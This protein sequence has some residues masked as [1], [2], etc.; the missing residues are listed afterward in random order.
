MTRC[1]NKTVLLPPRIE[2]ATQARPAVAYERGLH[3][4]IGLQLWFSGAILI[5]QNWNFSSN[6]ENIILVNKYSCPHPS[7]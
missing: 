5:A 1:L 7:C 3:E 2:V 6:L 4:H